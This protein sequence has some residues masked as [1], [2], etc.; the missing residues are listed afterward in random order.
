[1]NIAIQC[2]S[3]NA[4][5]ATSHSFPDF[6]QE[7]TFPLQQQATA[8]LGR[9]TLIPGVA[10]GCLQIS[11][12]RACSFCDI[13]TCLY[14]RASLKFLIENTIN[15][16]EPWYHGALFSPVISIEIKKSPH[17]GNSPLQAENFEILIGKH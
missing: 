8:Q 2:H 15:F 16:G 7:Q 11:G 5:F 13:A 1:M 4:G 14:G 10:S 17:L 3:Y 12:A 9:M 6:F